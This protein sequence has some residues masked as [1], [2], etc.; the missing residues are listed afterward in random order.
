MPITDFETAITNFLALGR[1]LQAL[2]QLTGYA[3]LEE[4]TAEYRENRIHGAT[5]AQDCDMVLLQWGTTQLPLVPE[6]TDLRKTGC[7]DL[8][9]MQNAVKY[10][11]FARQVFAGREAG[12]EFDDTAVQMSIML[13][14]GPEAGDEPQSNQWIGTPDDIDRAKQQYLDTP[15]VRSLMNLPAQSIAITVSHCG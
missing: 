6:P 9:F 12:E 11:D 5:V 1:R 13:G 3:V 10:L 15:F 2:E 4:I 14:F 7:E 8:R